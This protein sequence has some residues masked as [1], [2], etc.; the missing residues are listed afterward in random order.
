MRMRHG[1]LYNLRMLGNG[2]LWQKIVLNC[3][4]ARAC[5]FR[6]RYMILQQKMKGLFIRSLKKFIRNIMKNRE[7][8]RRLMKRLMILR[9]LY[10]NTHGLRKKSFTL[11]SY[12]FILTRQLNMLKYR[13]LPG[14]TA[15]LWLSPC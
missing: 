9:A 4:Q 1:F 3:Q 2:C 6:L 11:E 8:P 7:R 5:F 12:I 15:S 10:L 13:L 14:Q